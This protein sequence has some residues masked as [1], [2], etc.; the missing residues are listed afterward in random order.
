MSTRAQLG[1]E[2][3]AEQLAGLGADVFFGLMGEDTAGVTVALIERGLR[4]V[5]TRHEAAAVGMADGYSWASGK[6]GIALV[7]RGPG[8][9]NGLTAA[10]N[11]ARAGE[12]VLIVTGDSPT[13]RWYL[14]D[15]KNLDQRK[16]SETA[17][18]VFAGTDDPAEVRRCADMAIASALSGTPAVL[19]IA[20]NVLNGPLPDVAGAPPVPSPPPLPELDP[21]TL[22]RVADLLLRSAQP[23]VLA[24]RGATTGRV[25]ELLIELARRSGALLGTTLPARD[26]FLGQP[27]DLGVV[28]GFARVRSEEPLRGVDFVLAVGASLGDFTTAGQTLFQQAIVAQ[29]ERDPSRSGIYYPVDLGVIGDASSVCAALVDLLPAG[30]EGLVAPAVADDAPLYNG[31]DESAGGLVDPRLVAAVLDELLPKDRVVLCDAGRY[32]TA[33]HRFMRSSGLNTFRLVAEAG[34]I[35]AGLGPAIGAALARPERQTVLCAGDGGLLLSASDLETVAREGIPLLIIVFNDHAFGA[36][37]LVLAASGLPVSYAEFPETDI[38]AIA[39]GMGIESAT[40]RSAQELRDLL[41]SIIER[42]TPALLDCKVLP[43]LVVP[44]MSG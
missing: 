4:Y 37:K 17:G 6:L 44:R 20:A 33:P 40:V 34:A 5:S 1:S 41:P 25:P 39:R 31:P 36:E 22:D 29:V 30:G 43:D 2:V 8:L 12:R 23:L 42:R 28:G 16:L 11:A 7:T 24:G 27:N 26:L 21:A 15:P 35:G 32:S 18:L 10:R 13:T 14:P 19:A 38:A 3:I 9:M